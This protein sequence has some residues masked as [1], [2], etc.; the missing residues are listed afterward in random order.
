MKGLQ[1][2]AETVREIFF[3]QATCLAQLSYTD[4]DVCASGELIHHCV[5][6]FLALLHFLYQHT[7]LTPET[8]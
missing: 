2:C 7:M 4:D 3:S 1:Y 6:F 5:P 8:N